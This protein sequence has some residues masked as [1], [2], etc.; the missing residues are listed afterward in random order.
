MAWA[1]HTSQ[2]LVSWLLDI[3]WASEFPQQGLTLV[4]PSIH[5]LPPDMVTLGRSRLTL[6]DGLSSISSLWFFQMVGLVAC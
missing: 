1:S 5:S 6:P 4:Y 2:T 3:L